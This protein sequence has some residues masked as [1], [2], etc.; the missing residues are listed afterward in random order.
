MELIFQRQYIQ[1]EQLCKVG[2]GEG[3]DNSS[4]GIHIHVCLHVQKRKERCLTKSRAETVWDVD[5][6]PFGFGSF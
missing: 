6:E 4:R 3:I 5:N 2:E 1:K